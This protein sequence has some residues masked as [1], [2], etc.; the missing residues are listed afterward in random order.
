K[1]YDLE[2]DEAEVIIR[3]IGRMKS[4]F[5][6]K[7]DTSFPKHR[8]PEKYIEAFS[9]VLS[10]YGLKI[11]PGNMNS[12]DKFW[13]IIKE[14]LDEAKRKELDNKLKELDMH[15]RK[16]YEGGITNIDELHKKLSSGEQ[17]KKVK[18]NLVQK[19]MSPYEVLDGFVQHYWVKK[20]KIQSI[21]DRI[22]HAAVFREMIEVKEAI[23]KKES[24]YN[25]LRENPLG[26]PV[27][28]INELTKK[29]ETVLS[30]MEGDVEELK[31]TKFA[32][33]L[34]SP[35]DCIVFGMGKAVR[36]N[37]DIP[38]IF[39]GELGIEELHVK[40]I[41]ESVIEN[42]YREKI[43]DLNIPEGLPPIP[44]VFD[45]VYGIFNELIRNARKNGAENISI[46]GRL[47]GDGVSISVRDDGNGIPEDHEK[48]IFEEGYS[49]T[50]GEGGG[51][52]LSI[53]FAA[54]KHH[55]GTVS[56]ERN[57]IIDGGRGCTFTVTLSRDV[58]VAIEDAERVLQLLRTKGHEL[59][60]AVGT[61]MVGS[62]QLVRDKEKDLPDTEKLT[63]EQM[64]VDIVKKIELILEYQKSIG[65]IRR[66]AKLKYRRLESKP[67][68]KNEFIKAVMKTCEIDE[69][70]VPD[71][72]K[73]I[74]KKIIEGNEKDL[75]LKEQEVRNLMLEQAAIPKDIIVDE[76]LTP[77]MEEYLREGG[78]FVGI[79]DGEGRWGE[80]LGKALIY[81]ADRRGAG[82]MKD[83]ADDVAKFL[84]ALATHEVINAAGV[85]DID[86][87]GE[88]LQEFAE[89]MG[90]RLS[91]EYELTD[92][93]MD[94]GIQGYASRNLA[95]R[96]T[97]NIPQERWPDAARLLVLVNSGVNTRE[98]IISESEFSEDTLREIEKK[99]V[100]AGLI[101]ETKAGELKILMSRHMESLMEA[102]QLGESQEI[103]GL[104]REIIVENTIY[105]DVVVIL[106]FDETPRIQ[107]DLERLYIPVQVL[108]NLEWLSK[109]LPEEEFKGRMID[110]AVYEYSHRVGADYEEIK[111][112]GDET[113]E[114]FAD[115]YGISE[116]RVTKAIQEGYQT[117]VQPLRGYET[118]EE[119][120]DSIA[121]HSVFMLMAYYGGTGLQRDVNEE[122]QEFINRAVQ[123]KKL[124]EGISKTFNSLCEAKKAGYEKRSEKLVANL[125]PYFVYGFMAKI[126]Q[127]RSGLNEL[128]RASSIDEESLYR[129]ATRDK[130]MWVKIMYH[131]I[132]FAELD[133]SPYQWA[134]QPL[135]DINK[136]LGEL[137]DAVKYALEKSEAVASVKASGMEEDLKQGRI[138]DKSM[139]VFEAAGV[140]LP[141]DPVI[142]DAGEGVWRIKE[143]TIKRMREDLHIYLYDDAYSEAIKAVEDLKLEIGKK[144]G[145]EF[146]DI[147]RRYMDLIGREIPKDPI[148]RARLEFPTREDIIKRLI[149]LE[150][151]GIT[152]Y[153]IDGQVASRNAVEEK[154]REHH[155]IL[156]VK[157]FDNFNAAKEYCG[158][159]VN[160]LM[161]SERVL[162]NERLI[163]YEGCNA[164]AEVVDEIQGMDGW[165]SS[166]GIKFKVDD[167]RVY[168]VSKEDYDREREVEFPS[169]WGVDKWMDTQPNPLPGEVVK[170]D[171]TLNTAGETK[172][173][174]HFPDILDGVSEDT[175]LREFENATIPG[176]VA[177]NWVRGIIEGIKPEYWLDAARLLVLVNSGVKT[178]A[179]IAGSG[180]LRENAI[181]N[182][183]D[184][185][186]GLIDAGLIRETSTGE[187]EIIEVEKTTVGA[188]DRPRKLKK[189]P[190]EPKERK[191]DAL[192]R[193]IKK[194]ENDPAI[195][196]L[197]GIMKGLGDLILDGF[198]HDVGELRRFLSGLARGVSEALKTGVEGG[199]L[200]FVITHRAGKPG[201]VWAGV[202]SASRDEGGDVNR[203]WKTE[204]IKKRVKPLTP[205][206]TGWTQIE[207]HVFM[208]R[209]Q[210]NRFILMRQESERNSGKAAV[211][212]EVDAGDK[213]V[214]IKTY[215][216]DEAAP[217]LR[218]WAEENK[219]K[220]DETDEGVVYMPFDRVRIKLVGGS[221]K[222][223]P[224]N[225]LDEYTR[226]EVRH[227]KGP[228]KVIPLSEVK[229]PDEVIKVVKK[230]E[231]LEV[232]KKGYQSYIQESRES[233][234]AHMP[235]E[236]G[237]SIEEVNPFEMDIEDLEK[238]LKEAPPEEFYRGLPTLLTI[239]AHAKEGYKEEVEALLREG[240]SRHYLKNPGEC[241]RRIQK[242]LSSVVGATEFEEIKRMVWGIIWHTLPEG[243]TS[244][245]IDN[246]KNPRSYFI[247]DK[248]H[249]RVTIREGEIETGH[250]DLEVISEDAG[251]LVVQLFGKEKRPYPVKPPEDKSFIQGIELGEMLVGVDGSFINLKQFIEEELDT[252]LD[253]RSPA[254]EFLGIPP[255]EFEV[256]GFIVWDRR[257]RE[258]RHIKY[259]KRGMRIEENQ[260]CG[261]YMEITPPED[262]YV[263]IVGLY[264]YHPGGLSG[265]FSSFGDMISI[266]KLTK[267][268]GHTPFDVRFVRTGEGEVVD[269]VYWL[270]PDVD[271]DKLMDELTISELELMKTSDAEDLSKYISGC[272]EMAAK[273]FDTASSRKVDE[274]A[275][276]PALVF[277]DE[278]SPIIQNFNNLF[279]RVGEDIPEKAIKKRCGWVEE[280]LEQPIPGNPERRG[281]VKGKVLDKVARFMVLYERMR[282]CGKLVGEAGDKLID[283]G[284]I[285]STHH[286]S[287]YELRKNGRIKRFR[288]IL[289][290][291]IDDLMRE[292]GDIDLILTNPVEYVK[293]N[294]QRIYP[295][296]TPE[297]VE[298]LTF[299]AITRGHHLTKK[300]LKDKQGEMRREAPEEIRPV[301]GILEEQ[302]K[303]DENAEQRFSLK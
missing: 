91:A 63:I 74:A 215:K 86:E 164:V 89:E 273:Y 16:L 59:V 253:N 49:T 17:F 111:R 100:D 43:T 287:L 266:A 168:S 291:I 238:W 257:S 227:E 204:E 198:F 242:A 282:D 9:R 159:R 80:N 136:K 131:L 82:E 243:I 141:K 274:K 31:K 160:E 121:D 182:I 94:A 214:H 232:V 26:L 83:T 46:T 42:E 175:L 125:E 302:I 264:H 265:L 236:L 186:G 211:N 239:W 281:F 76:N 270:K 35:I 295:N 70:E 262:E 90:E 153:E 167:R 194:G 241:Q 14:E 77:E 61:G 171:T 85:K 110:L 260:V 98:E 51:E 5:P 195:R 191:L 72:L 210:A 120:I 149:R 283:V 68:L 231:I 261:L 292:E 34:K 247:G 189:R 15:C 256:G 56:V 103:L 40:E 37:N 279:A 95:T 298:Y 296:K 161:G 109:F 18:R 75:T 299:L 226:V 258:F 216:L 179:E 47:K 73:G 30:A 277:L 170:V 220:L 225:K 201:S 45:S 293:R 106:E 180:K 13:D 41:I 206:E 29:T 157:V 22:E 147:L 78:G 245:I 183:R 19:H 255:G 162:L 250:I 263:D 130:F 67:M 163:L 208:T 278:G 154:A 20:S 66:R 97:E 188:I 199:Y 268:I 223:I 81:F 280:V 193:F 50:E 7:G 251:E 6:G 174:D 181:K 237:K 300:E 99:L 249:L 205:K 69:E 128:R 222:T 203:Y 297:Q 87:T 23:V 135:F 39:K 146:K 88:L 132:P 272:E 275:A 92:R 271:R 184:I 124:D 28:E 196:P 84:A 177:E 240:L 143:Y 200:G 142:E 155:G 303:G 21:T 113:L 58:D 104:I 126:D 202:E 197:E 114:E 12:R 2:R 284:K 62:I 137:E 176:Y 139:G 252:S 190:S 217:G 148:E 213:T 173:S 267:S 207:E 117:N 52:G 259:D 71:V 229:Y 221:E 25:P 134:Y 246:I 122:Y 234:E 156:D 276:A 150:A 102:E 10:E 133:K 244:I 108:D 27:E 3:F 230:P 166:Q 53:I 185:S 119:F 178:R 269:K 158:G 54:A 8:P 1:A 116:S 4:R 286:I 219:V 48:K 38:K 138:S 169:E 288:D 112:G 33:E 218:R 140:S 209:K 64:M 187:F 248:L 79:S 235:E 57:A 224:Y 144:K 101:A 294:I 254:I 152:V 93:L 32:E 165:L 24:G 290:E 44:G 11:T 289:L 60:N 107:T 105:K 96:I 145:R 123:D 127:I 118:P 301:E 172:K 129:K 233:T 212:V 115:R 55:G 285:P 36:L 192:S 228:M 151:N 65:E